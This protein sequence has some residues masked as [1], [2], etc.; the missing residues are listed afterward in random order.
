LPSQIERRESEEKHPEVLELVMSST[1]RSPGLL[2]SPLVWMRRLSAPVFFRVIWCV[3]ESHTLAFPESDLEGGTPPGGVPATVAIITILILK[4]RIMTH[5]TEM[6]SFTCH[7]LEDQLAVAHLCQVFLTQFV[8]S[9]PTI[10]AVAP[11]RTVGLGIVLK[12]SASPMNATGGSKYCQ[13][14]TFTASILERDKFQR[15]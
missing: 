3:H 7:H 13:T 14:A 8:R 15:K 1:S 2:G 11:I 10:I 9:A 12:I 4:S 5:E 6:L